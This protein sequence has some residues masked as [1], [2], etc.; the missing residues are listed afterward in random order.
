MPLN[1]RQFVS[2]YV[3]FADD[4]TPEQV[5][6]VNS[7]LLRHGWEQNDLLPL[8]FTCVHEGHVPEG[9]IKRA[10][11]MALTAVAWK[12]ELKRCIYVLQVGNS[13]MVAGQVIGA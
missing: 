5:S 12:F 8:A 4:A 3:N 10:V 2:L 7:E 1:Q 6:E 9:G 13:P 11:E